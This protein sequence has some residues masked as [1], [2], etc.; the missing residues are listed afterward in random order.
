MRQTRVYHSRWVAV[1]RR[2]NEVLRDSKRAVCKN[3]MGAGF[4]YRQTA[5][6]VSMCVIR[7]K[8]T[9]REREMPTFPV[10][11]RPHIGNV[12]HLQRKLNTQ[13]QCFV[14]SFNNKDE[15]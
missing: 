5:S 3:G 1:T 6:W 8:D 13:L 7:E 12:L 10:G 4:I 14:L 11:E 15:Y 2:D 9:E